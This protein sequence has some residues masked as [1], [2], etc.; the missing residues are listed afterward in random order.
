MNPVSARSLGL[1][2]AAACVA[3]G[4][5]HA[6]EASAQQD[7][8]AARPELNSVGMAVDRV[9][10]PT[11]SAT[12]GV[13]AA[14]AISRTNKG[15]G[16]WIICRGGPGLRFSD[17][18][19]GP[20]PVSWNLPGWVRV[21]TM[22]MDFKHSP[23]PP[24]RSGRNLQPGE[25]SPEDFQFSGSDP[26][27]I[28]QMMETFGQWRRTMEGLPE[29]TSPNVAEKYPDSGNVPPYLRDPNHYWRFGAADG[30]NGYLGSGY[31]KY[32]TPAMYHGPPP[33]SPTAT[34]TP[35]G[36]R[37]IIEAASGATTET[38]ARSDAVRAAINATPD[39]P[40]CASARSARARN[41]PA[42]PGLE[43]QCRAAGGTP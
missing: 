6:Q 23:L 14:L 11:D 17:N 22:I 36:T 32:W 41:S 1:L 18:G 20:A 19:G 7:A 4:P 40:I 15:V 33:S 8:V 31:S 37:R 2:V 34:A 9:S 16:F 42:A 21:S 35:R 26:T 38:T 43:R 39:P 24:D 5:V 27:Q 30:G 29:D 25:C 13:D 28:Q 3:I 12:A 10:A